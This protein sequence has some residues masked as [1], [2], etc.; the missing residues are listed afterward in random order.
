MDSKGIESISVI[1]SVI[2]SRDR[3]ED[4]RVDSKRVDSKRVD[5][6]GIMYWTRCERH[7]RTKYFRKNIGVLFL[8]NDNTVG[9]S[10]WIISLLTNMDEND[11]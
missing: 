1:T 3:E 7:S 6:I 2:T 10:N 4:K 5:S 11:L 8:V 9:I